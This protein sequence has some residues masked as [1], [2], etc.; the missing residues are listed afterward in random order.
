[1]CMLSTK[2]HVADGFVMF[3]EIPDIEE[4]RLKRV[5]ALNAATL[6]DKVMPS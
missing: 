5:D 4:C 3:N 1:M 2:K 6:L